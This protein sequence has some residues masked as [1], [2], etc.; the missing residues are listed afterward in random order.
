MKTQW[1]LQHNNQQYFLIRNEDS[2]DSTIKNLNVT[3]NSR[4]KSLYDNESIMTVQGSKPAEAEE[5]SQ[6]HIDITYIIDL[7][8]TVR[9]IEKDLREVQPLPERQLE[10][11]PED[12]TYINHNTTITIT[13]DDN[14][15]KF[16]IKN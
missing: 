10:R 3:F 11:I 5:L 9:K 4:A 2:K 1:E 15:E 8:A 6:N 13:W 16:I 7:I 14:E 12:D